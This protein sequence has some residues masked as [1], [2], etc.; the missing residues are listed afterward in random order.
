MNRDEYL[1]MTNEGFIKDKLKKGWEKIKSFLKIGMKK[2][3]DFIT[4]FD[5][6][7]HVLPV[8]SPQAV[9]D[10]FSDSSVVKVLGTV[11][12]N[13]SVTDA[14]GQINTDKPVFDDDAMYDYGPDG[15]EFFDY[16]LDKK[17][18]DDVEYKNL[19][20]IPSIIQ[21]H[22]NIPDEE[23][24]KVFEDV[25]NE[26]WETI[27][28]DRVNYVDKKELSNIKQ[29]D[30]KKF[31]GVINQ[32]IED[33]S[34]NSGKSTISI[35]GDDVEIGEPMGNILVF[36]APGI[37]KSTVPHAVVDKFNREVAKFDQS[38]MI[39]LIS[40]NCANLSAGDFM[41][42]TMPKENDILP[43][44]SEF[45]DVFPQSSDYLKGLDDHQ[46]KEIAMTIQNSGQFKSSDAPKCWLPSYKPVGNNKINKMLDDYSNG[47]VY[48]D[49]DK[50]SYKTGGGGI[51]L[52]DEL[53]RCDPD[54]FRQLMIFLLE[55]SLN[56]WVLGSKWA[57]IACSNR[58]CDDGEVNKV[59]K[60]WN[61]TP[62]AK[63]R[64]EN[65]YQLVPDPESWKK[66]ARKKGCDE[67]LI[68]FMFDKES[69]VGDEYPRWHSMVPNSS[70]A[71][72][73]VLPVTP[74]RWQKAFSAIGKYKLK[75]SRESGEKVSDLSELSLDEIKDCLEG[76]FDLDFVAEITGW[77]EDRM[78]AVDLD[79]IMKNPKSV[80]LPKKFVND[81]DKAVVLIENLK[82]EFISR[83][84][85]NPED[86]SDDELSNI[87]IWLGINY[88]GDM[89]N[90]QAFMEAIVKDVFKNDSDN[91]ISKYIKTLQTV[92]AAYPPREIEK[93]VEEAENEAPENYP[94][95]KGSMETIKDLM[96]EYFP[97]RI[98]GDE[99]K[100]YDSLDINDDD[101]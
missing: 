90:V 82:R 59:W 61:S 46:K 21:E 44:I 9:M 79:G 54:V 22:Y 33:W 70:S 71:A 7:G 52:F 10:N 57:L 13:D 98:S 76:Y 68:E 65:M 1:Q 49:K 23:M 26:D 11:A 27:K 41:M 62:A 85:K 99:I 77:L 28:K 75:K 14:G 36:G 8:V 45:E 94:W 32:L 4:I 29:I 84:K 87:F 35:D 66:W 12:M 100:Y 47:G 19:M 53:L 18:K 30:I 60:S 42:P 48:M 69:M 3:K 6:D 55:R 34:I 20:S 16:V 39:S 2:I 25:M 58:P 83:F 97:W 17:Y 5:S 67:L 40:I 86:C 31:E 51:I 81:P 72:N 101:E 56:G 89:F 96:R 38:K 73:Q 91:C 80:Y 64:W 78:D 37:G 93:D 24:N 50:T 63:D 74:R 88:P 95:P 92:E 43:T 15:E